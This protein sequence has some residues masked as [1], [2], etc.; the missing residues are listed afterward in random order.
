MEEEEEEEEEG[1]GFIQD[2]TR[3]RCDSYRHRTKT[4]SRNC[5]NAG[6]NLSADEILTPASQTD[7][8]DYFI[9]IDCYDNRP[10]SVSRY[11]ASL[12]FLL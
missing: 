9:P 8:T 11:K 7:D 10:M 1:G 12:L 4:L 5:R 3:A 2:R 6:F